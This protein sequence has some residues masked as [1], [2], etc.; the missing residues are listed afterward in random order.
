MSKDD[1]EYLYV[2]ASSEKG[3]AWLWKELRLMKTVVAERWVD[4][5][6]DRK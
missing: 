5:M 2:V 3:M 4:N 1:R 6:R